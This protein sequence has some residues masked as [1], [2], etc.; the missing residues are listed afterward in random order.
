M[1]RAA[2]TGGAVC[3]HEQV[4]QAYPGRVISALGSNGRGQMDGV[5]PRAVTFHSRNWLLTT[6]GYAFS[7]GVMDDNGRNQG[8]LQ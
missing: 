6:E 5:S 8:Q 7:H 1:H 2:E 4:E 3:R